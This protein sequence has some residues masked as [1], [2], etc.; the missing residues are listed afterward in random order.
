MFSISHFVRSL[1]KKGMPPRSGLSPL[2][3]NDETEDLSQPDLSQ[4]TRTA[5]QVTMLFLVLTRFLVIVDFSS[6]VK[7]T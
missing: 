1:I 5:S 7:Y 4:V 6:N 2:A 3:E